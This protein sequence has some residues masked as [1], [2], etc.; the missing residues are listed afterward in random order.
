M[1]SPIPSTAD[2]PDLTQLE[3]RLVAMAQR[4][5][6]DPPTARRARGRPQVLPALVLWTALTLGVLKGQMAQVGIWRLITERVWWDRGMIQIS[7]EA[8]YHRL[9][10]V[11]AT[12]MAGFFADMTSLLLAERPAAPGYEDLAPFASGVYGL[13]ESTLPALAKRIPALKALPDGDPGLLAGKLTATFDLR[14]HLFHSILIQTK[15]MQNER[16]AARDAI[17]TLPVGALVLFDLGYF[18]FAWFDD[19]EEAGYAYVS[20]VR[21]KTSYETIQVLAEHGTT[22]DS[23]IWLGAHRADRARHPVRLIEFTVK[24]TVRRYLTNVRDPAT[25]SIRQVADLYALRWTIER[26]FNLIKTDLKL[27]VL[28]SSKQAVCHHQIWAI[29]LIAQ[30]ILAARA[31]VARRADCPLTWV[32]VPLLVQYLPQY[33]RTYDDPIGQFV[34]VGRF[35]EFIRPPRQVVIEV[36]DVPATAYGPPRADAYPTRTPRYA[37]K[38]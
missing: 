25:L 3:T 21:A 15:G 19:L 24:G 7:K 20:R 17:A 4:F 29:L 22:R 13:D 6:A 9:S 30:L 31:E 12:E 5:L 27:S 18:G 14:R 28:W 37:G 34:A 35:L 2:R 16:V 26:A 23:L 8:V 10:S 32:S 38:Q 11:D 36:P 1:S 33:A